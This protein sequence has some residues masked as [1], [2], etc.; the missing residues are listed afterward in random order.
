MNPELQ[1]TLLTQRRARCAEFI[2]HPEKF[3]VCD[4]CQS[5]LPAGAGKCGLCHAYRFRTD[6]RDVVEIARGMRER[7]VAITAP[8]VPRGLTVQVLSPFGWPSCKVEA[9]AIEIYE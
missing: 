4:Q 3:K 7:A 1:Q 9:P 5:M 8:V 2:A 6:P